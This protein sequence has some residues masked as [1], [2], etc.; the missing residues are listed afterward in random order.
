MLKVKYKTEVLENNGHRKEI[1]KVRFD[2]ENKM[3]E[4]FFNTEVR[5]F[6][7]AAYSILS[8][9][10]D[11]DRSW[12]SFD[13]NRFHMLVSRKAVYIDDNYKERPGIIVE[14]AELRDLVKEYIE[15]TTHH[16]I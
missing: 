3:L 4:E 1:V 13:G 10:E 12:I 16:T 14:T 6:K 8:E 11:S 9:I 15:K 5:S 7:M 2:K